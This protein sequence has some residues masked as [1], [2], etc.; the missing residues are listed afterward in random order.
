VYVSTFGLIPGLVLLPV[1]A[2]F[3]AVDPELGAKP[4]LRASIGKLCASALV[5]VTAVL[6][7]LMAERHTSRRRAL[8]LA[9]TYGIGSC[10]WAVSSQ[11]M[12]QQTLNQALLAAGALFLLGDV[13]LW[14]TAA[15]AGAFFGMAAACR[16]TGLIAL[17]AAATHVA[18]IRRRNLLPFLV[19]ALPPLLGVAAY[20]THYFGG[21]FSS[22]QSLAGHA[23]AI[24]KT[25][26]PALWQTPLWLGAIGLLG[27]PSR[28]LLVFSPVL[29]PGLFGLVRV[30]A[31]RQ[32]AAFRPLA[33][34]TVSTMALQC[35]WFDW[36][37]G[38]TYGYRPWL[39]VVPY[40]VLFMLPTLDALLR[41]T[42]RCFVYGALLAWSSLVQ[43]L[44]AFA[45]DHTWNTRPLYIVRFADNPSPI[46]LFEERK[47][48]EAAGSRGGS[49]VGRVR[50]DVDLAP[51]RYRLWSFIDSIIPYSFIHFT[52]GRH[53]R[54]PE[55]WSELGAPL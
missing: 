10:A 20:N 55:S 49:Y 40:L 42:A 12:W 31:D 24:E 28:G 25:G 8:L 37:G 38:H 45:Y 30:L 35:K 41:T 9:F 2:P 6:L 36:W 32:Y 13:E 14:G 50:C 46:A 54:L 15:L 1:V 34:Y 43:A 7:F 52:H 4:A 48:R 29:A 26:S 3:F 21:I 47:A 17:V 27:S 16:A 23:I 51:C 5:S 44:G 22:G 18:L 19:L 53:R 39:D 33:V 11:S